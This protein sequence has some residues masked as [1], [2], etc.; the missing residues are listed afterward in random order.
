[1]RHCLRQQI[2]VAKLIK[3]YLFEMIEVLQA[4]DS[5]KTPNAA[6]ELT[7]RPA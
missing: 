5:S 2:A 1:M 6:S 3:D 4:A 7:M